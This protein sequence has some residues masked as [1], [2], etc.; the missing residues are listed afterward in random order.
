MAAQSARHHHDERR[1]PLARLPG[2]AGERPSVGTRLRLYEPT[3]PALASRVRHG[4]GNDL[5][6]QVGIKA[7]ADGSPWGTLAATFPYLDTPATRELDLPPGHRAPAHH[8]HAGLTENFQAYGTAD[9]QL[10]CHAN[11]DTAID[12]VGRLG[13]PGSP[14]TGGFAPAAPGTRQLH[15]TRPVHQ[16]P[17]PGRHVQPVPRPPAL[18]GRGPR[19]R[20]VRTG[21]RR[22]M[23]SSATAVRSDMWVWLHN[24]SPVTPADPLHTISV[25]TTSTTQ[26]RRFLGPGERI[27]VA[28]ALRAHTLDAARQLLA[29]GVIGSLAAGTYADLVVLSRDPLRAADVSDVDRLPTYLGAMG[30]LRPVP[31]GPPVWETRP[32]A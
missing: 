30:R 13:G 32:R 14:R 2:T 10:A 26:G 6:R 21:H 20:A 5:V 12:V 7:W 15:A 3:T 9:P 27:S 8:D 17:R 28:Q 1:W 23:G 11:G 22:T 31:R 19:R 25:A 16:D 4:H 29:G 18:L 24:D